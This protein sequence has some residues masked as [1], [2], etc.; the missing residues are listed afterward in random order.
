MTH[1]IAGEWVAG[2]GESMN[3]LSPYNNEVIWQGTSATLDQ[4]EL[5][6]SAARD[7]FVSWKKM[8]F[9]DRQAIVL[10]FAEKVKENNTRDTRK[11]FVPIIKKNKNKQRKNLIR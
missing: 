11:E 4:V 2:Q 7:A 6:V 10:A 3:S 5:A 9:A 1:W 8:S